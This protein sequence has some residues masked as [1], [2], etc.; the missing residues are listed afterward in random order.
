MTGGTK[1]RFYRIRCDLEALLGAIYLDGGFEAGE[2]S[3]CMNFIL[4][5][6]E[7]TSSCF[8]DSKTIL[9]EI[10]QERRT[11]AGRVYSHRGKRS[12]S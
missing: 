10:V 9:Q 1:Q 3:L 5:D 11:P 4:N 2:T 7:S 8:Y 6:I 12:G